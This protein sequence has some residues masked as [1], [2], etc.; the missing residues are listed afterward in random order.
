M[1]ILCLMLLASPLA[2]CAYTNYLTNADARGGTVNLVSE[3]NHDA[4]LQ[5]ANEHCRQYHLVARVTMDDPTSNSM[6]FVCQPP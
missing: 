5:K 4:A 6:N 2:G 1:R 3:F